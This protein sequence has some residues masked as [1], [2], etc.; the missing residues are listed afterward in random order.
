MV[1]R[2]KAV[3]RAAAMPW[4]LLHTHGADV[5]PAAFWE[6]CRISYKGQLPA[7]HGDEPPPPGPKPELPHPPGYAMIQQMKAQGEA[8]K[9]S[10]A[11]SMWC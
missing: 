3:G 9:A 4:P 10:A 1:L 11:T 5:L 2:L 7:L 6:D 8:I